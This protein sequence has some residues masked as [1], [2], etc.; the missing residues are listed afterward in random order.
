MIHQDSGRTITTHG[1]SATTQSTE[2]VENHNES[3]V[4]SSRLPSSITLDSC[5]SECNCH[6]CEIQSELTQLRE[7]SD[8]V[9]NDAYNEINS[10]EIELSRYIQEIQDLE[11]ELQKSLQEEKELLMKI[12]EETALLSEE[13]ILPEVCY[14]DE[15]K[16]EESDD[17]MLIEL[18][19]RD[20]QIMEMERELEENTKLIR[21]LSLPMMTLS[22]ARSPHSDIVTNKTFY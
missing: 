12:K 10:S 21:Y 17:D 14:I 3:H 13:N 1:E 18:Q 2:Q 20:E 22:E 15:M 16:E 11:D 9:L 6:S 8:Q 5:Y 7:T 19:R 4:S